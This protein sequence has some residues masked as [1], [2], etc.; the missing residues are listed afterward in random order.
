MLPK[1]CEYNLSPLRVFKDKIT[2]FKYTADKN[3]VLNRT[4]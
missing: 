1:D 4:Q 3:Y 2:V